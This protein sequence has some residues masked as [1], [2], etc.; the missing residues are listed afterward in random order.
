LTVT[1]CITHRATGVRFGVQICESGFAQH[2]RILK[3][4][5]LFCIGIMIPSAFC[6]SSVY[7]LSMDANAFLGL[8]A[9]NGKNS[10]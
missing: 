2:S 1:I 10:K 5:L 3:C 6:A 8:T 4:V 7:S 9:C